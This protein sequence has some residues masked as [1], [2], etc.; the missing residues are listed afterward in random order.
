MVQ[1]DH[2][3]SHTSRPRFKH[4]LGFHALL[5]CQVELSEEEEKQPTQVVVSCGLFHGCECQPAPFCND[6]VDSFGLNVVGSECRVPANKS[7]VLFNS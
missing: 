1:E 5:S 4:T 3:Q 7:R 6:F 2:S